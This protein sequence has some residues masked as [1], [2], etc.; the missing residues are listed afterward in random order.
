MNDQLP[1]KVP[2]QVSTV[3]QS[4]QKRRIRWKLVFAIFAVPFAVLLGL[5]LLVR[6]AYTIRES[7][8]R[9]AMQVELQRLEEN[10]LPV[11]N[12]TIDQRYSSRTSDAQTDAWLG[13]FDTVKSSD[14]KQSCEGIPLLD[15]S[16]EYDAT[17]T[18]LDIVQ[19]SPEFQSSLRFTQQ[20][21]ELLS[22]IRSLAVEP[23]PV[24]F[25]IFF[26]SLETLLQ[27]VQ[28]TRLL[29]RMLYTDA[30]VAMHLGNADRAIDD[31]M[32]IYGLSEHVR[33][34]PG[35]V[36]HLCAIAHRS[37]ALELIN[38][39][40]K[41]DLFAI[42]QLRVLDSK[43]L[44]HCDIGDKWQRVMAEEMA[45]SLPLFSNPAM[46]M[47]KPGRVLPARGHDAIHFIGLM[48]SALQ[49]PTEDLDEFM[50]GALGLEK[51]Q[52]SLASGV[53]GRIDCILTGLISPAFSALAC[54]F[55]ND[56]QNHRLARV[57][58]SV[59]LFTRTQD[60]L[61]TELEDL[62]GYE[63]LAKPAGERPFG[64]KVEEDRAVL[65]G[66]R[67]SEK[68]RSVEATPPK[69]DQPGQVN[70]ALL[71]WTFPRNTRTSN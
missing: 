63:L 61:P 45:L 20:H 19:E 41:R 28:D 43:V 42:E 46:T 51:E 64:Y 27:E 29:V 62:P 33:A 38:E 13:I 53:W 8:G 65:W 67:F 30:N 14:F 23:S 3:G 15:E 21:A 24:Y 50:D 35:A 17:T 48:K 70:Y 36:P 34:V 39:A 6:I 66:N 69:Q 56:A 11:D 49:V 58:I 54:V 1:Y 71:I 16:I 5:V 9:A 68:Q 31:I 44:P 60:K 12:E 55:I 7:R 57:A 52:E 59:R 2:E 47:D 22:E 37:L 32:A 25:P 26:Q 18:I 40:C 10:G 4:P